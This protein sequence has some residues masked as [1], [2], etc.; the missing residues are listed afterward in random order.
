MDYFN[1]LIPLIGIFSNIT[2]QILSYKYL[3]S[4][5]LLKSEYFGFLCGLI[6][7][8]VCQVLANGKP[9]AEQF[10]LIC[11][12]LIIYFCLSYAYFHFINLGE[13]ARRIRL[14]RELYEAPF[15]LSRE[16]IL[17]KYNA[18]EIINIRTSR[19][20]NNGQIILRYGRYYIASPVMLLISKAIVLMKLVVLGKKSEFDLNH[21]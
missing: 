8:A 3:L 16:E 19:L 15:G 4:R 13:T 7:L 17:K 20:L 5:R 9:D 14:L 11:T 21:G 1:I 18:P 2:A 6:V 12:N 10:S